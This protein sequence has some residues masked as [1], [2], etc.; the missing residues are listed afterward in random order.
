MRYFF[1]QLKSILLHFIFKITK[2]QTLSLL[3]LAFLIGGF[4]VNSLQLQAQPFT[5]ITPDF[6]NVPY[7]TNE[8]ANVKHRLDV[9][10][11]SDVTG[12]RPAIVYIHGGGW[13]DI[14]DDKNLVNDKGR[15][16][17]NDL[18]RWYNDG[19]VIVNISYRG[20]DVNHRFPKQIHDVKA[21]IRF[22]RKN[23]RFY[24]I[25]PCRIG[26]F[27]DSAGAHL[28]ALLGTSENETC[29]EG[30]HLGNAE[31][32]SGVQAVYSFA[33]PID[34]N[35]Q[36]FDSNIDC[37]TQ[38]EADAIVQA[39]G[40]PVA[41]YRIKYDFA[42]VGTMYHW[43]LG[44]L[45]IEGGCPQDVLDEFSPLTYI[46]GNEPP[47]LIHH[48]REDCTIPFQNSESLW[49]GLEASNPNANTI[50]IFDGLR[51][52]DPRYI[53]SEEPFEDVGG[54]VIDFF[55]D[56]IGE[57]I[58]CATCSDGVQN[59]DE[60]GIDCGGSECPACADC[61]E[62]LIQDVDL[63]ICESNL[64]GYESCDGSA[65]KIVLEIPENLINTNRILVEGKTITHWV[66]NYEQFS[67][68]N[69]KVTFANLPV[70]EYTIKNLNTQT[71]KNIDIKPSIPA[72]C[73]EQEITSDISFIVCRSNLAS[74][75]LC[76]EE[77]GKIVLDLPE[78]EYD[79]S[80]SNVRIEGKTIQDLIDNHNPDL[81]FRNFYIETVP[82]VYPLRTYFV[83]NH[84]PAGD[85]TIDNGNGETGSVSIKNV[86]YDLTITADCINKTFIFETLKGD[87]FT[88]FNSTTLNGWV[89]QNV[90]SYDGRYTYVFEPDPQYYN[91][92]YSI[93]S[94]D[95]CFEA[96]DIVL[97]E[98]CPGLNW[99]RLA[100]EENT[101]KDL[102][103]NLIP[104]PASQTV[105]IEQ[106][107]TY[108]GTQH[109]YLYDAQGSLVKKETTKNKNTLQ[110]NI[111]GLN[112]GVYMV[113]VFYGNTSRTQRLV[114]H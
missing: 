113:K 41:S 12:A 44:C 35:I 9:Y 89:Q 69:G 76:G 26:A 32:S 111:A 93:G 33:A 31:Y 77:G 6:C 52:F 98:M 78:A 25:D 71:Q 39:G 48:G 20:R 13:N 103:F 80:V 34:L 53:N 112:P 60:S 70:G 94:A 40:P 23:A 91:F 19:Y 15:T 29:L 84:L 59:G 18:A 67:R 73:T 81:D 61:S 79:F 86:C 108:E 74:G 64:V 65:G 101:N 51:H 4:F 100:N 87:D 45:P 99:N 37:M 16:L 7:V 109:I 1:T 24:Q 107:G 55:D 102:S 104:N 75:K 66:S 72:A 97:M 22:I 105:L 28:A 56:I 82:D 46:D 96:Y 62:N 5:N 43:L 85:Y 27:G 95:D 38:A 114:I 42:G 83:M 92:A 11:P 49:N 10:I 57:S 68:D 90:M 106:L 30:A 3:L 110:L 47:F 58:D 50:M 88:V 14:E 21:A 2:S 63:L 17:R 8:Y 54:M 36:T